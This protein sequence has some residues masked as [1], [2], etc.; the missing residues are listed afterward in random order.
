MDWTRFFMG[1]GIGM[2]TVGAIDLFRAAWRDMKARAE[3]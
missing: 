3:R 1:F 2:F